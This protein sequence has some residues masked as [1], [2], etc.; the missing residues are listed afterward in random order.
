MTN[1][2]CLDTVL[3]QCRMPQVINY[4]TGT[5]WSIE[6]LSNQLGGGGGGGGGR[7]KPQNQS[8]RNGFLFER[9][10]SETKGGRRVKV[11]IL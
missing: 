3:L 8:F 2:C 5:F 4:F 11:Y 6:K 7:L 10:I 1:N 9:S